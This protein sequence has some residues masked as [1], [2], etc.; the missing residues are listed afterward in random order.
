MAAIMTLSDSPARDGRERAAQ[1]QA[2][3]P[4]AINAAAREGFEHSF[5]SVPFEVQLL[6]CETNAIAPYPREHFRLDGLILDAGVGFGSM[7]RVAAPRRASGDRARQESPTLCCRGKP[8]QGGGTFSLPTYAPFLSATNR[9]PASFPLGRS[10][11][12]SKDP[13]RILPSTSVCFAR[14]ESR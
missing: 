9:W 10:N 5:L 4:G 12:R 7:G 14:A 13:R 11:T 2:A 8:Q 3:G 1:H 6:E